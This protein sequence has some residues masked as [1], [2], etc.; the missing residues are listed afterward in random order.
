MRPAE[1]LNLSSVDVTVK[2]GMLYLQA[3]LKEAD[4]ICIYERCTD[5]ATTDQMKMQ[6]DRRKT[7]NLHMSRGDSGRERV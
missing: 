6:Y 3:K 7:D 1:A 5:A 2:I 4:Q